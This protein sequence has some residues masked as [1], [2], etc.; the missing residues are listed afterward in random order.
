MQATH[1][2]PASLG[3]LPCEIIG[4]PFPGWM[5]VKLVDESRQ[6]LDVMRTD[7]ISALPP[8]PADT[9]VVLVVPYNGEPAYPA[10]RQDNDPQSHDE[11]HWYSSG[12]DDVNSWA[13]VLRIGPA[14][15][16]VPQSEV[17]LPW[18][19]TATGLKIKVYAS[20]T[21]VQLTTDRPIGLGLPFTHAEASEVAQALTSAAAKLRSTLNAVAAATVRSVTTD[22]RASIS[23]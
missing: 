17:A 8:E 3:S 15:P 21:Q 22:L 18:T 11:Y 20:L 23:P 13:E 2:L 5:R 16:M 9:M 7:L 1:R 6:V 10:Q 14:I 4:E 12:S 19:G